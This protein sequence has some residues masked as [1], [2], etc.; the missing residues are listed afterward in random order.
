MGKTIMTI[1]HNPELTVDQLVTILKHEFHGRYDVYETNILWA[2]LVIKKSSW[3]GMVVNL[4]QKPG[5]TALAYGLIAPA[6]WARM[7]GMG[8]IP[9]LILWVTSWKAFAADVTSVLER[10]DALNRA[11]AIPLTSP[12]PS[13]TARPD[14]TGRNLL[15]YQ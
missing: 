7:L 5:E 11:A 10:S 12:T 4:K 8:V 3:T 13:A 6:F 14:V 9:Y 1:R 2:D 15:F